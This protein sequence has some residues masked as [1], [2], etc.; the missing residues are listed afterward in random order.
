METHQTDFLDKLA[1]LRS[2]H[3]D[4]MPTP[5]MAVLVRLTAR[6]RRSGITARCLQVGETAPDFEFAR[7]DGA[8]SSLYELLTQGPVVVNFFRG[9][10]C[11][12]CRTELEAFE[13][14]RARLEALGCN[15]IAISP[16]PI[17][18]SGASA[19]IE[20]V[21]DHDNAI[22]RQFDLVYELEAEERRLFEEWGIRELVANSTELPLPATYVIAADRTV[23]FRFVDVD[24]RA[25]CCPDDLLE[26][27]K[28]LRDAG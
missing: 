2:A 5:Q 7:A 14:V 20:L 27:V 9:L 17:T 25:R 8:R 24:F 1:E 21:Y 11:A 28:A 12:Y 16:Q 6:L 26:E 18:N 23:A 4:Q 13:L 19:G 15:Y 3:C 10:W 22:A